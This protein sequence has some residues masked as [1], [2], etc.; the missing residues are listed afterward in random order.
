MQRVGGFHEFHMISPSETA[1]RH[2][3]QAV[4]SKPAHWGMAMLL[5]TGC[6]AEAQRAKAQPKLPQVNLP[7]MTAKANQ[8]PLRQAKAEGL[9]LMRSESNRTGYKN[10]AFNQS[11]KSKP[12]YA[13]VKRGGERMTLGSFATAEEAALHVAGVEM[14]HSYGVCMKKRLDLVAMGRAER[15]C[16]VMR[17]W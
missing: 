13:E 11:S 9:T 16:A 5:N 3:S 14:L 4:P 10:V 2:P 17:P 7:K 8:D 1:C 12:Y 15:S 6:S